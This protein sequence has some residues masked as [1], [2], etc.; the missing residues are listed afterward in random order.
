MNYIPTNLKLWNSE[1]FVGRDWP[2]TYISGVSQSR[3]SNALERS[4]FECML[5]E[6]GG[7]SDTVTVVHEQHSDVGWIEWIAIKT[8]D[9][10]SLKIADEIIEALKNYPTIDKGHYRSLVYDDATHIWRDCYSVL[11]RLVYILKHRDQFEFSD[12]KDMIGCIQGKWCNGY[13]KVLTFY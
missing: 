8:D 7:E 9:D 12:Y 1:Y 3:D 5:R 11:K 4:N 10:F 13:V 6:L 2:N